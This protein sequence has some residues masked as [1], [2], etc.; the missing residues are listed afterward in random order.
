MMSCGQCPRGEG[1]CDCLDPPP[2]GNP[3]S[4]PDSVMTTVVY[5][6]KRSK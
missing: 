5:R 4:A 3:I 1:A 6:C 2:S